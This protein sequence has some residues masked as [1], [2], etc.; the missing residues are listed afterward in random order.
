M[1]KIKVVSIELPLKLCPEEIIEQ[2]IT[3][4]KKLEHEIFKNKT[5]NDDWIQLLFSYVNKCIEKMLS[6]IKK[7]HDEVI[8]AIDEYEK[9]VK[10]MIKKVR[11]SSS[12]Y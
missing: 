1:S 9:S 10:E 4:L 12:N 2:I 3:S 8:T 5:L 7:L 11:I 6:E